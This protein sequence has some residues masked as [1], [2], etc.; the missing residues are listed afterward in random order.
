MDQILPKSSS[1]GLGSVASGVPQVVLVQDGSNSKRLSLALLCF[2]FFCLVLA[3]LV[4]SLADVS[5]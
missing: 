5:I 4:M 1:K 2:V 3:S